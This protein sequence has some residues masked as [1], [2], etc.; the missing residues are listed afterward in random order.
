MSTVETGALDEGRAAF[1]RHDWEKAYELL[2]AAD[3]E[4]G[5]EGQ[6]LER[7]AGAAE[8]S[9][10]YEEML[11]LLERAEASYSEAGDRRSAGRVAL[12][13]TR[14]YYERQNQS[15]MGGWL[16]RALRLLEGEEESHEGGLL[17]WMQVHSVLLMQGDAEAAIPLAERLIDLGRRLSDR[18]L[19]ALGVL[20]MGH[21]LI[22]SGRVAEG[23]RLLDEANALAG[24]ARDLEVTGTIYCSTIFACRNIGDWRR[25]AEWTD[26]S[27]DWCERNSV[28]GFPGLCRLHR[29]EVIRFRGSLQ[30][31]E[32]DAAAACEELLGASP[33]MAGHAFHELG[34]VLRRKGDLDKARAAFLRALELG[35]DPQPGHALLMLDEA[36]AAGALRTLSRRL[37]DRDGFTQEGR[38][39]L[40][41]AQVTIALAA[42]APERAAEALEELD[43]VARS[44]AT[45]IAATSAT[46]ARGEVALARAAVDD[47]IAHLRSAWRTWCDVGAPYEA[48]RTRL[49]LGRAYREGG[50]LSAARVE[51]EGARD[52]FTELGSATE[53]RRAERLLSDLPGVTGARETHTF[54]FTDIVDSTRLVELLGDESWEILL[55]WHDRAL[56]ACFTAHRGS[57]V[58]HEGDGFFVAFPDVDAAL[59]CAQA[60]QHSMSDHRRESGFAPQIRIGV[61]AAEATSRA[62]DYLGRGV[63]AAA[64]VAS[65]GAGGEILV[66]QDTLEDAED[67]YKLADLGAVPLKGLSEPVRLA[68]IDWR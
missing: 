49:L 7:L 44:C 14:A 33:V 4:Q 60:I 30:E 37:A 3:S 2:S 25:A 11:R 64:R 31:A 20:E 22:I 63:H 10:R 41:P 67:R 51:L 15:L 28:S 68:R 29:S 17:L 42:G 46:Q 8:W 18:D 1:E 50:D 39:L 27:L 54:M 32:R 13:L 9:R 47:A 61:H 34:E 57:E 35:F 5:L 40:L 62:G 66:S 26:R 53:A 36:D 23:S 65:A 55:G 6:D 56:R 52:A 24:S 45:P 19:E 38:I 21:A 48:A 58:K 12:K 59:R 43:E 16:G